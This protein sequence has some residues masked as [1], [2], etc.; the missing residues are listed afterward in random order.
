MLWRCVYF[1]HL[2]FS[3]FQLET[4]GDSKTMDKNEKIT[5][6]HGAGGSVMHDLVKN[7]IVKYFGGIGNV[8]EVPLEAMDDAA[9][10]G[11]IVFKSDSHAVKPI[12]FPGGDIGR[13][14]ISGTVND[15]SCLGAEPYALAC[16]LILEEGLLLSDL[17]RILASMRQACIEAGVGIVT[18]DTK[19]VEKGSLGGC[20]MSQAS[21]GARLR[22]TATSKLSGSI[23]SLKPAG[24]WT[25]TLLSATKSYCQAPSA[26]TV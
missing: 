11:D 7:Y 6:L 9:V 5:M 3:L 13:L 21:A 1:Y 8:A 22:S 10:I 4:L 14:S 16:G 23:G 15:I 26:T 18:G 20:V 19:V 24:L 2:G 17:E 25:Q 12:F